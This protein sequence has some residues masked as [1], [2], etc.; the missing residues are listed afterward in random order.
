MQHLGW[1]SEAL[2][3]RGGD[4]NM[5]HTP[6]A[7]TKDPAAM[8]GADIAV[9]REV[10]KD[11]TAQMTEVEDAEVKQLLGYIRDHEVYHE[12]LFSDLLDEIKKEQAP[13]PS[14]DQPEPPKTIPS[15]GSLKGEK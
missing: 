15:V 5:S 10:T 8:L 12:A 9:E 11:Y 7:L 3:E 14:S 6:L 1:L 4:P 13:Q 2:M